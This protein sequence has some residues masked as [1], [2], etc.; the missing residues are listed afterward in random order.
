GAGYP[1]DGIDRP[2]VALEAAIV[3]PDEVACPGPRRNDARDRRRRTAA[4]PG[5]GTDVGRGRVR[6]AEVERLY[7]RDVA[8]RAIPAVLP[9]IG[10]RR[11]GGGGTRP[12]VVQF[13]AAGTQ[14]R[15]LCQRA[16]A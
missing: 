5:R 7:L 8:H 14:S 15:V 1:V 10:A 11:D 9:L 2:P 6:R 4:R 3:D 13:H 12:F 16:P